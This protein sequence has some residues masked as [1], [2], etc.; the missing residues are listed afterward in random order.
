MIFKLGFIVII[1]V[2][3]NFKLDIGDGIRT[4]TEK[5]GN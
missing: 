4:S 3:T 2:K 1:I 5:T